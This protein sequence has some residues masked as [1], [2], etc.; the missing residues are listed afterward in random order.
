MS[1]LRELEARR[2]RLM[3][4]CDSQRADLSA[5]IAELRTNPLGRMA[6]GLL[7]RTDGGARAS[8]RPLTLVAVIAALLLLRR[9]RQVVAALGLA[10][11][12]LRMG[13]RAAFVLGLLDQWR[14]RGAS[15]P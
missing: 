11:A 10:R 4:R 13:A 1:R 15:K 12:A 8:G 9:P 2:A 7:G 6:R 14:A 3:A 5:H